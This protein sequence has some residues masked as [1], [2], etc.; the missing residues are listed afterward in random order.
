MIGTSQGGRCVIT[1]GHN[2]GGFAQG[3]SI[4]KAVHAAL[5]HNEHPMHA[6]YHPDRASSFLEA[7]PPVASGDEPP[8]L[9]ENAV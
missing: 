6:S 8:E 5:M 3:P 9:L 4:A 1:G 2:T 7:L